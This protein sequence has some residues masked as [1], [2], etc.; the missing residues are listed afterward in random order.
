MRKQI[1]LKEEE[2]HQLIKESVERA[3][4]DEGF[5]DGVR[6]VASAA[7]SKLGDYA[8]R[9]ATKIG[10]GI[11]RFDDADVTFGANAKD[12]LSRG[13]NKTKNFARNSYNNA[14]NRAQ[15]RKAVQQLQA[16]QSMPQCQNRRCANAIRNLMAAL[17]S[18]E[19]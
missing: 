14:N 16:M 2:L 1:Q 7:K 12:A 18:D 17:N 10:N 5:F 9:A 19:E 13:W 11:D 4:I 6:G 15:A 8:D 3:L